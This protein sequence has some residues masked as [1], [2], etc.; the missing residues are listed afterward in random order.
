MLAK[1][2]GPSAQEPDITVLFF[3]GSTLENVV[4]DPET[5]EVDYDD[6][7]TE[8]THALPNLM[9]TSLTPRSPACLLAQQHHPV[10][11]G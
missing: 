1:R 5:R 9:S 11:S 4:F 7:T 2:I 6:C 8:N 10:D 3:A